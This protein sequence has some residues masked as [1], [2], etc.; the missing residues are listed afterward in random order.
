MIGIWADWVF[1][2]VT[3]LVAFYGLT[4]RDARG[5]R[6]WV[7]LMFGGLAVFYFMRTLLSDVLGVI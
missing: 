7:H 2:L 1:L 3:G 4:Y 6:P 5:E